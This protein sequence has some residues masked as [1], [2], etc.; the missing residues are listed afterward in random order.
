[1]S[2]QL[3]TGMGQELRTQVMAILCEEGRICPKV[4]AAAYNVQGAEF[5]TVWLACGRVA[6]AQPIV[7]VEG[8]RIRFP[9]RYPIQRDFGTGKTDA[10]HSSARRLAC[11]VLQRGKV[12][13]PVFALGHDC[14][15]VIIYTTLARHGVIGSYRGGLVV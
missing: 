3:V 11:N 12:S 9:T 8:V 6:E 15:F 2:A 10:N 5:G 1:M 4:D 14:D 7:A 13:L